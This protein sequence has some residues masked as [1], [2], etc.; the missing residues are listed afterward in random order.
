MKK[1]PLPKEHGCPRPCDPWARDFLKGRGRP[2]PL[3]MPP[4][5]S[6]G[7]GRPRPCL[8]QLQSP[9]K[10]RGRPFPL[11]YS[12]LFIPF[13]NYPKPLPLPHSK[14]THA[15]R[16]RVRPYG[17]CH[18]LCE[19]LT[20]CRL[21]APRPPGTSLRSCPKRLQAFAVFQN[22]IPPLLFLRVPSRPF[23]VQTLH[24]L[25]LRCSMFDVRCSLAPPPP[26][27]LNK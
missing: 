23:A 13:A 10:G 7:H 17:P 27:T 21:T 11:G 1:P 18:S 26:I 24:F 3:G 16:P 12:H 9:Q 4:L 8:P 5:H 22:F 14:L 20:Q 19:L 2:F 15:C 25:P 6:K